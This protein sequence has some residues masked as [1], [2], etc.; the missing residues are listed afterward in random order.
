MTVLQPAG[1]LNA[2]GRIFIVAALACAG[3]RPEAPNPTGAEIPT[4]GS[5]VQP[6][7]PVTTSPVPEGQIEPQDET[8]SESPGTDPEAKVEDVRVEILD[9]E[10]TRALA[11]KH[12]GKVV[13]MDLWATYCPPCI[14]E[15]PNLVRLQRMYPE[16]LACISVSCDYS[17][18]E[19]TPESHREKVTRFLVKQGAT[20]QNVILSTDTETLFNSKLEHS[21]I[22]IVFVFDQQGE[23]AG[24]FPDPKNAG[25]FT[26]GGDVIPLIEKLL[27]K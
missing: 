21:G 16:Q 22:P 12:P 11:K 19:D 1:T 18:F 14:A 2:W 6:E 26:Y 8:K 20:F 3:C 7:I 10:A 13:V 23:L 25:E 24:Q 9:W 27:Q 15:F 4:A 17:G 5:A